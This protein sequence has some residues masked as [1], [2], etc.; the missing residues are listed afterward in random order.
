MIFS[1]VSDKWEGELQYSSHKA[2]EIL[3]LESFRCA[4]SPVIPSLNILKEFD[5]N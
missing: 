4:T 2:R 1:W 5:L 3:H